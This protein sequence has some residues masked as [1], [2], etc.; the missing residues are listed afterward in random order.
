MM[1]NSHSMKMDAWKSTQRDKNILHILYMHITSTNKY[2]LSNNQQYCI[3]LNKKLRLFFVVLLNTKSVRRN[4]NGN[5]RSMMSHL[6]IT[7]KVSCLSMNDTAVVVSIE[8]NTAANGVL[9]ALFDLFLFSFNKLLTFTLAQGVAEAR[10]AA[11]KSASDNSNDQ[12]TK[13]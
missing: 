8:R 13:N 7:I 9:D 5:D 12:R 4:Q 6:L 10:A 3:F 1:T 2:F 11:S